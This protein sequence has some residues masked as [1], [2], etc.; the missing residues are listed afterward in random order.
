[1]SESDLKEFIR[2]ITLRHERASQQTDRWLQ[3]ADDRTQEMIRKGEEMTSELRDLR[4][5]MNSEL[6]DLRAESRAQRAAL[7]RMLDRLGPGGTEP[8]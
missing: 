5:Q 2:E 6:R 4:E 3:I 1:M 8:A 7:F